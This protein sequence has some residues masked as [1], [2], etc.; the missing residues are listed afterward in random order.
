MWAAV[1]LV[2]VGHNPCWAV[3][4]METN[5]THPVDIGTVTIDLDNGNITPSVITGNG[6]KL[7]VNKPGE[8]TIVK[9]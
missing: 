6:Y 7:F 8:V 5:T 3:V 1:R 9:M 2:C 4:K